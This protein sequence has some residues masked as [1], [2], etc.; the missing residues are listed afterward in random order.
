MKSPFSQFRI[1]TTLMSYEMSP[2][3]IC[4]YINIYHTL[5]TICWQWIHLLTSIFHSFL[6]LPIKHI[7]G[8]SNVRSMTS[9][10]TRWMIQTLGKDGLM[11]GSFLEFWVTP[12]ETPMGYWWTGHV[13][14][15]FG[16]LLA[17]TN[18]ITYLS[19]SIHKQ[20]FEWFP[21]NNN[22]MAITSSSIV[23]IFKETIGHNLY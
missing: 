15:C 11:T 3:Y 10:V 12:D 13:E 7:N 21:H 20:V 14:P 23:I 16:C 8:D 18:S 2:E 22:T 17:L 5:N 4:K 9:H 6:E 1:E 19:E